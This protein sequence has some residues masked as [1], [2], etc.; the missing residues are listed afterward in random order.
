MSILEKAIQEIN[1]RIG[2]QPSDIIFDGKIHRF[3]KKDHAWYSAHEWDFNGKPYQTVN[4]GSW[5]MGENHTVKSWGVD[6]ESNKNF[7]KKFQEHTRDAK[8]RMEQE[9]QERQEKCRLKWKPIFDGMKSDTEH[10]YLKFKG[11]DQLYTSKAK[12]GVLFV[13]A[14]NANRGFVGVQRIYRSGDSFEKLFSAGIEI[15]GAFCPLKPFRN[16]EYGYL[17]EG[18]ATAASIQKAF[19]EIPVICV[20]NAG[21]ISPAI[22]NIRQL[23]PKI[24]LMIA[25]DKDEPDKKRGIRAGEHY[26]SQASKRFSGVCYRVVKFAVTNPSWTDFNDLH[27]FEG[28]DKVQEQLAIDPAEFT[29]IIPLGYKGDQYFYTSTEN[30]QIITLSAGNHTKGNLTGIVDLPYWYKNY[31]MQDDD[32]NYVG[33]KWLE[34]E[35]ALKSF[36]RKKGFFDPERMRG[37]GVWIDDGRVVINTGEQIMVDYRPVSSFTTTYHYLRTKEIPFSIQNPFTD[38]E[39]QKLLAV[40]GSLSLKNSNDFCI[41]AAWAVQAE[42]FAA[43]PWRF[44]I[45]ISGERG[46]GKSTVQKWL[47]DLNMHPSLNLDSSASGIRQDTQND[48]M[49]VIYDESEPD[50]DRLKAVIEL[51]RQSSSNTGFDTRRGTPSGKAIVYNSQNVFCMG[52]IQRGIEKSADL[53]R[54]FVVELD[55]KDQSLEEYEAM[56]DRVNYFSRNKDRLFARAALSVPSILTSFKIAQRLI[57]GRGVEARQ[58]DQIA[59]MIACFWV[60][61]SMEPIQE[62]QVTGLIE[63]F[64]LLKSDY[65]EESNVDDGEQCYDALM[66]MKVDNF[67]NSVFKCLNEIKYAASTAMQDQW[68]NLLGAMGMRFYADKCELFIAKKSFELRKRLPDHRDYSNLLKRNKQRFVR[69][70]RQRVP[71]YGQNPRGIVIK[72]TL[73]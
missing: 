29:E 8:I 17:A 10:E 44:H 14:Y 49:P 36:C 64:S 42:I 4:F 39:M 24:K 41:L 37:R 25:A 66:N 23:H 28:I 63:R 3:G 15:R 18:F 34:A 35:S 38:E 65:T 61:F 30:P 59:S 73:S 16:S 54:F 55:L 45:W 40:F 70:D 20:F 1:A 56:L 71:N 32:G 21:N 46:T 9:Q 43:L 2:E 53:S 12:D 47:G 33:V 5:K 62:H 52:S 50:G 48:A 60:Y 22:E 51:A 6:E 13:P 7:R 19:P 58:A 67:N 11:I 26:A 72:V 27:Q 31:G 69:E 57:R 68:E